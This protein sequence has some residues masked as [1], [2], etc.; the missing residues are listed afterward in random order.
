MKTTKTIMI[1]SI[2]VLLTAVLLSML[3]WRPFAGSLFTKEQVVKPEERLLIKN[4]NSDVVTNKSSNVVS[5]N[6]VYVG[7]TFEVIIPRGWKIISTGSGNLKIASP[8]YS[9]NS[10]FSKNENERNLAESMPVKSGSVIVINTKDTK[11]LAT[12]LLD[13][14]QYARF[15]VDVGKGRS[16]VITSEEISIAGV[17][18]AFSQVNFNNGSFAT[19]VNLVKGGEQFG[20]HFFTT[21]NE[22][23]SVLFWSVLS[24]FKFTR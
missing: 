16:G 18:A 4:E 19:Y 6:E 22:S 5:A 2:L 3:W 1:V 24:S 10:P 15:Y 20:I 21:K 7:N 13:P 8:D 9:E 12:R 23:D 11:E 14:V 17:P